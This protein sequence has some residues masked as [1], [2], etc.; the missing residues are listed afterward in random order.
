[1]RKWLSGRA[2]PCQGEGREFESRLPL[3][4]VKQAEKHDRPR[5]ASLISQRRRGQVA[6]RR[7][8]KPLSSVR[9]R[10]SPPTSWALEHIQS[11]YFVP[12]TR[13]PPGGAP[14]CKHFANGFHRYPSGCPQPGGL[15]LLNATLREDPIEAP[16]SFLLHGR[17]AVGVYVEGDSYRRVPQSLADDLRI[18]AP[19]QQ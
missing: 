10:S 13:S 5:R 6:R 14:A 9:I 19:L 11:P 12:C 17:Q 4:L 18:D 8:A 16:S 1:M 2:S 7:S 3:H 15:D